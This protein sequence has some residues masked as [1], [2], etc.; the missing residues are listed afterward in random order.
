MIIGP[1][2]YDVM[3]AWTR[4]AFGTCGHKIEWLDPFNDENINGTV[5]RDIWLDDNGF[6][7]ESDKYTVIVEKDSYLDGDPIRTSDCGTVWPFGDCCKP[8]RGWIQQPCQPPVDCSPVPLPTET[9][10]LNEVESI[11]NFPDGIAI[12]CSWWKWY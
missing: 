6:L 1:A 8:R 9:Y 7:G 10:P 2:E 5:R 12:G 11:Q 4:N 3:Q